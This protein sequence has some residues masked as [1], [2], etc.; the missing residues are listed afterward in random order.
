M[1]CYCRTVPKP[2]PVPEVHEGCC[3]KQS[4]RAALQ[5]LCDSQIASLIDFDT[6]AFL[7]DTYSAGA[8][9]STTVPETTPTDNLTSLTGSFLR[10]SS[11]NC[12]LL[13]ISAPLYVPPT[14]A[15]G[16]T[17]TQV[18]LCELAAIALQVAPGYCRGR[19]DRARGHHSEL[20]LPQAAAQPEAQ[21]LQQPVRRM[22][23]QL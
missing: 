15:T 11:C 5:L 3:C 20:P 8:T 7:T 13:E 16:V 1:V 2:A 6:A 17:A 18:S 14:T 21:S 22:R 10:L 4:F 9:L 23:V 19:R 12:D